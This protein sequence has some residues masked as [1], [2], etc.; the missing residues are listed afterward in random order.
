MTKSELIAKL[1]AHYPQLT[2]KDA[3]I[4]A[5]AILDG[6]TVTLVEGGR[7]EIR[8]FGTFT[9]NHRAPRIARNPR[10]GEKVQVSEKFNP[11]FRPG[12][13]LRERVDS[14]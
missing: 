10:T 1:A 12:R 6:I 5:N 9:I 13:E 11:H 7:I 3:E 14:D 8:G 4:A 2:A